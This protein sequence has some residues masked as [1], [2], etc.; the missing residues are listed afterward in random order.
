MPRGDDVYYFSG[1]HPSASS[2]AYPAG[3]PA[4]AGQA[5][6]APAWRRT[7]TARSTTTATA[8]SAGAA[9]RDFRNQVLDNNLVSGEHQGLPVRGSTGSP[10]LT[11]P[12]HSPPPPSPRSGSGG[13]R[14]YRYLPVVFP[15]SDPTSLTHRNPTLKSNQFGGSAFRKY[16]RLQYAPEC[17]PPP[18]IT[19][20]LPDSGPFGLTTGLRT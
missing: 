11:T 12:T 17:Q 3:L 18:R 9:A 19:R 13:P 2:L 15:P 20:N 7:T 4:V 10:A 5:W 14:F 1:D 6:A 16:T 8:R